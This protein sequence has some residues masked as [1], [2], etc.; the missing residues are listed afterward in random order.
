MN[1]QVFLD[2][3]MEYNRAENTFRIRF[4][5]DFKMDKLVAED[6]D[7]G[8]FKEI[9]FFNLRKMRQEFVQDIDRLTQK[10]ARGGFG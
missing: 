3:Y 4:T 9:V 10:I 8:Q 6:M 1:K 2:K 7:E 5:K